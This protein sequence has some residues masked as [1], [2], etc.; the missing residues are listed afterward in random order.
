MTY[1]V[2]ITG[3]RDWEDESAV[4]RAFANVIALHGPENIVIVHGACP[5]G[6]DQLADQIAATWTGLTV[7][8]H[9]ADWDN[10]APDCPAKPHRIKK[11]MGDIHHPGQM[12]DYCPGAGPRRNAL[13]VSLGADE[14]LAFPMPGSRGTA[15]CMRL[16]RQAGIPVRRCT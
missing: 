8:R 13:M 4:R 5:T 1:R 7:E 14:C 10:C 9:P 16:A 12:D 2:L 11:R 15:N 3:S 6:A